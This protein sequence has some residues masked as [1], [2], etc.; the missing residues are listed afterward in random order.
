MILSPRAADAR[1]TLASRPASA[2]LGSGA[3]YTTGVLDAPSPPRTARRA[4]R[5]LAVLL[6]AGCAVYCVTAFLRLFHLDQS[7]DVFL[8]ETT[9]SRISAGAA[10][11]GR[12]IFGAYFFYL[13]GP[14]TFYFQAVLIRLFQIGGTAIQVIDSLRIFNA[15]VGAGVGAVLFFIVSYA[16]S[17]RYALLAAFLFAF[18]PFIISF[19]SRLF[20]ETF[21]TLWVGL[22]YLMLIRA[23][24]AQPHAGQRWWPIAAGFMFGLAMLSKETSA[25][26]YLAP[27]LWCVVRDAP[28]RR[29]TALRTLVVAIA[30]YLPYPL[31]AIA[32]GGGSQFVQQ[33]F[34]GVERLLGVIQ[35]TGF[36]RP[37]A[38]SLLSRVTADLNTFLPTYVLIAV[39]ALGTVWLYRR[40][41]PRQ[42]VVAIWGFG[43][44]VMLAFQAI[45]GTIEEQMFY[46][47]V[48]PAIVVVAVALARLRGSPAWRGV[49]RLGALGLILALA[50]FDVSTWVAVHTR[51]DA[52]VADTVSWIE[53]HLPE[54]TR[55]APLADGVQLLLPDYRLLFNPEAGLVNARQLRRA[56]AQ[57]VVTSSLQVDQRYAAASPT[58][59]AWL[60]TH[61]R[62]RHRAAGATAGTVVVWQLARRLPPTPPPGPE[63]LSP[64][65]PISIGARTID[66]RR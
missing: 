28:I 14:L 62:V 9:Y 10:A 11:D 29:G 46:Y 18:D 50:V 5:R 17:A 61:A 40:G 20:L 47:L 59:I 51:R 34:N 49:M 54:G 35:E 43:A 39:G 52:A 36:N 6:C 16:A 57:V 27:I 1:P 56:D 37:N 64:R 22:G 44:F 21:A 55:I 48:V 42:R 65:A 53:L 32:T 58:L 2:L 33:K 30:T 7:Y 19:D 41:T 23:T 24:P 3:L 38:P 15:L 63:P 26:L 8:D 31:I 25:P 12:L 13:H 45:Q 66:D 60:R 4:A